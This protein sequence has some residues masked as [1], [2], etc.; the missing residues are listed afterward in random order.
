MTE[1]KDFAQFYA[2]SYERLVRQVRSLCPSMADAE[3][4]VQDAFAKA[5][6]RWGRVSRYDDPLAWTRLVAMNGAL[7]RLRRSRV[8]HGAL[9]MLDL[10]KPDEPDVASCVVARADLLDALKRLPRKQQLAVALFHLSDLP[11]AAIASSTGES[12]SNVRSQ[13]SRGRRSL[14]AALKEVP[15]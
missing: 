8:A 2:A 11:I 5:L 6:L 13:L 4:C 7:S 14:A 9:E 1:A 10:R 15:Q 12:E 3:D